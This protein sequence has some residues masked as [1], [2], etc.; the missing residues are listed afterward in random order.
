MAIYGFVWHLFA[1]SVFVAVLF[2]LTIPW[3]FFSYKIWLGERRLDEDMEEELWPRA[4]RLCLALFLAAPVFVAVD[5]VIAD[6]LEFP[7]GPIHIVFYL[8]FLSFAAWMMMFFF[9]LEDFFQGL[10]L[11]TIF[12]YLPAALFFVLSRVITWNPLFTFIVGWLK[13]P[14]A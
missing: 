12:L 6:Q 3:A 5:Y 1:W 9:S 7:S 13:E 11:S 10:M 8:G 14:V 4:W 2:P